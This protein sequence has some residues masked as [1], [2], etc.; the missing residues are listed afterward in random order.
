[1]IVGYWCLRLSAA[2]LGVV[3]LTVPVWPQDWEIS[4]LQGEVDSQTELILSDYQVELW[5]LLQFRNPFRSDVRSDGSF[6]F[7]RIPSG[8]YMAKVSTLAGEVAYQQIVSLRAFTGPL[9]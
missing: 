1:M 2:L 9:L 3:C 6:E 4:V 5:S 8:D 7:R